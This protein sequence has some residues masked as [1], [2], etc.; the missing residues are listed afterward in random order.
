MAQLIKMYDYISRYESNPFHY[1]TQYI[2]LKNENWIKLNELWKKSQ[3]ETMED[4]TSVEQ[5]PVKFNFN[6]FS[7]KN[8]SNVEKEEINSK[9]TPEYAFIKTQQELTYYFLNKLFSFQLKWASSTL[10]Q[11][12]F[13][14]N[15]IQNDSDLKFFL[16]SFPD[17]YLVMYR[18]I[19]IVKN[20]PVEGEVILI[21]PIG[22]E[23]IVIL[24]EEEDIIYILNDERTWLIEDQHKTSKMLSPIIQLKRTEQIVKS[25]LN[26]YKISFSIQKTVLSKTNRF[27]YHTE[28]YQVNLI[29]KNSFSQWHEQKKRLSSSLKNNQL[30]AIDALLRHCDTVSVRRPEWEEER[31]SQSND[32]L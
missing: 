18:P 32:L 28:P 12:S 21:S 31:D 27:L 22:I 2:Q 7:K 26:K 30:K 23:I 19:F 5:K 29:D 11:V 15:N 9:T 25:I 20:A 3:G 10:S 13:T 4:N 24:E 14:N 17:I 8:D 6:P 1:P 16:Q